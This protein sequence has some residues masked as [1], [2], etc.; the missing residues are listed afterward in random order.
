MGANSRPPDMG[1]SSRPPDQELPAG[2]TRGNDSTYTF[3][4]AGTPAWAGA[5]SSSG[6]RGR[7]YHQIIAESKSANSPVL[8]QIHVTKIF[9]KDHPETKPLNLTETNMT[10]LI[11]NILKIP[12]E[13]CIELDMQTGKYEDK[14]L[15]VHPNTDLSQ[16]L[17]NDTPKMFKQHE[18]LVAVISNRATKVTF[19]GVPINVPNEEIIHLCEHYGKPV[20]NQV[21]RQVMRLG[22]N[23]KHKINN[24]TRVVK[25]QLHPGKFMK[26]LYWLSGPNPGE[27][28]RRVTVLHANQP[29][30]CSHC[31]GYPPPSSSTTPHASSC[32]GGGNDKICKTMLTER[33]S[34]TNYIKSLKDEGYTSLRDEYYDNINSFPS[35]GKPVKTNVQDPDTIDK[36]DQTNYEEDSGKDP[37]ATR[38]R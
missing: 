26:N 12:G 33:T 38:H 10:D 24:S 5:G 13:N 21:H 31:L 16:A 36:E 19:K 20:N 34:M 27:R 30:Q 2:W 32:K 37:K 1:A 9:D 23:I 6:T 7:P 4:G 18:V 11:F 25:V 17:T 22:G 14:E 8:L 15:L 29:N 3:G 35:L 28:G